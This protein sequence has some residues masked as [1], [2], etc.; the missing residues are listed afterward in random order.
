M[1]QPDFYEQ[2]QPLYPKQTKATERKIK[3]FFL[4]HQYT[5]INPLPPNFDQALN[6]ETDI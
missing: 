6:S 3:C 5:H 2:A 1:A 4:N